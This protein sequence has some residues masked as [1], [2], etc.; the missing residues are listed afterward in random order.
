M[1]KGRPDTRLPEGLLLAAGA[2]GRQEDRERQENRKNTANAH[3]TP[4]LFSRRFR[5]ASSL[6]FKL[7]LGGPERRQM[8][9]QIG[10]AFP[11]LPKTAAEPLPPPGIGIEALHV[12]VVQKVQPF[13]G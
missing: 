3:E 6:R 1:E 7:A 12:F 4:P 13:F 10:D 2:G 11:M 5:R 8:P 9:D